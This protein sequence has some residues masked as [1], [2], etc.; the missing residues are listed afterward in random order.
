MKTK[1]RR[2]REGL[3]GGMENGSGRRGVC[4][5]FAKCTQCRARELIVGGIGWLRSCWLAGWLVGWIAGW[6]ALG[7]GS[8]R[9]EDGLW[10]KV[11]CSPA[12]AGTLQ[13]SRVG[14]DFEIAINETW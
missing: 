4:L 14:F 10:D 12:T 13:D 9:R 1:G 2:E 7:Q 8:V 6:M 5:L 11:V 3:G